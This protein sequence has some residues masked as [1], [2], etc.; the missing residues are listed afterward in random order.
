VHG[1]D[2]EGATAQNCA[3]CECDCPSAVL[4][5]VVVSGCRGRDCPELRSVQGA[6][7][8]LL[9]VCLQD[10]GMYLVR[11][12]ARLLKTVLF[13]R[14]QLPRVLCWGV[15]TRRYGKLLRLMLTVLSE[16]AT[17]QVAS[18]AVVLTTGCGGCDCPCTMYCC[19]EWL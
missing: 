11:Q 5:C 7:A 4:C 13:C 10:K 2:I 18:A 12:R 15:F 8:Q 17:A 6:T 16:G 14:V 9:S 19:A 1:V 3:Y